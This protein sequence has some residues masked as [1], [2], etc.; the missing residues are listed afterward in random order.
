MCDP[1]TTGGLA[2]LL[3]L[4][5][6]YAHGEKCARQKTCRKTAWTEAPS[7]AGYNRRKP[8]GVFSGTRLYSV[9]PCPTLSV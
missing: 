3:S 4:L 9:R 2:T 5:R 1:D 6:E 8:D 7:L